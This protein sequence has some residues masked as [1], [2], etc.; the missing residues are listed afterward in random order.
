M[1]VTCMKTCNK[2]AVTR[3]SLS[4]VQAKGQQVYWAMVWCS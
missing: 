1:C 3:H 4:V 2:L